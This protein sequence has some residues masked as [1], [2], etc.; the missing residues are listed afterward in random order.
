MNKIESLY[1]VAGEM[2]MISAWAP[3]GRAVVNRTW[4][5]NGA[6]T[7]VVGVQGRGSLQIT[8]EEFDELRAAMNEVERVRQGGAPTTDKDPTE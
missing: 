5:P 1:E 7:C 2:T 8:E 3:H 6:V 4:F